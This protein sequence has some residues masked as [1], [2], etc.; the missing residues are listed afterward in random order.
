MDELYY[1]ERKTIKAHLFK[2][3]SDCVIEILNTN[4]LKFNIGVTLSAIL[5]LLM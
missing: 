5:F 1:Y 4:Y 3:A 2:D